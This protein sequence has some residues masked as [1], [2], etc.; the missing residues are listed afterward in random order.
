MADHEVE[1]DEE[2]YQRGD[3]RND[4]AREDYGRRNAVTPVCDL[5]QVV[6]EALVL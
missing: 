4:G 5:A 3:E 1:Q 2:R 6:H